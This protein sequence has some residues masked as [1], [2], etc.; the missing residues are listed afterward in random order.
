M[1]YIL[2]ILPWLVLIVAIIFIIKLKRQLKVMVKKEGLEEVKALADVAGAAEAV[3]SKKG[4]SL[5][6]QVD[7]DVKTVEDAERASEKAR[8]AL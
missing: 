7:K 5:E 8:K 3:K 1:P 2:A 4:G 6:N